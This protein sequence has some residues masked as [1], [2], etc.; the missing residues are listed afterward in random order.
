MKQVRGKDIMEQIK[1]MMAEEEAKLAELRKGVDRAAAPRDIV[2]Q[3]TCAENS[4]IDI[5]PA[6]D[7]NDR[8]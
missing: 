5:T 7:A 1:V 2:G 4:G 3:S 8:A 6:L